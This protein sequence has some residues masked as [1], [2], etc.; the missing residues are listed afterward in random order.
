MMTKMKDLGQW[1]DSET[2]LRS[3]FEAERKK[4]LDIF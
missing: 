1:F 2:S 3:S 4:D